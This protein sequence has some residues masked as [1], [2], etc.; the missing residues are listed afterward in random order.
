MDETCR[1]QIYA[2]TDSFAHCYIF[3][4]SPFT[5]PASPPIPD[6]K[7]NEALSQRVLELEE[8]RKDTAEKAQELSNMCDY[9][10]QAR[11]EADVEHEKALKEKEEELRKTT[12]SLKKAVDT[13]RDYKIASAQLQEQIHAVETDRN[14]CVEAL[15]QLNQELREARQVS[16]EFSPSKP[17]GQVSSNSCHFTFA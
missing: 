11:Y 6:N 5:P 4:A 10:G 7:E 15:N 13:V 16:A 12:R 9:L 14:N 8:E 2:A 1:C 17:E 3:Q